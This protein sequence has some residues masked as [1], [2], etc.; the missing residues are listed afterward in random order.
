MKKNMRGVSGRLSPANIAVDEA[1]HA[2]VHYLGR[3]EADPLRLEEIE[4]R[5]AA[6]EKL[7]RKYGAT[8]EDVLAFREDVARNLTVVETSGERRLAIEREVV[9]LAAAYESAAGKLSALRRDGARRLAKAVESE[10]ASLA[11]EKTRVAIQVS[12]SEWSAGGADA[13]EFLISPNL[14]EEL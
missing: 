14:G 11:M 3:L 13:V 6:L 2:L 8:L 4:T 9:D 12:P 5:L 1:A 10:L 7:R